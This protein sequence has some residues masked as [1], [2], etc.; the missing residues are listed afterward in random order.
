MHTSG[1]RLDDVYEK[2]RY[3]RETAVGI[4]KYQLLK[5][6]KNWLL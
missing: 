3:I 6:E 4:L 1:F 2:I 5:N